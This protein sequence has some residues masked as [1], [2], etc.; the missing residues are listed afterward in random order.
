MKKKLMI[1]LP[2]LLLALGGVYKFAL[3]KP[4][5]EHKPKVEGEVYVLPKDFLLNLSDGRFARLNVALVLSEPA[6]AAGGGHGAAPAEPP[7]GFGPL[8][9]EALV[10]DIVTNS[11]LTGVDGDEL[12]KRAGRDRLKK[13]ILKT[14]GL[15]T[16]VHAHDVLF[17]DVAVQ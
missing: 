15:K 13:R 14:I 1:A 6:V 5:P 3:A 7:E 12:I 4:A 2:V 10:R 17:T 16:D 9:Q 8:P 11:S